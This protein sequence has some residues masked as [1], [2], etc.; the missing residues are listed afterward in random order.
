[1]GVFGSN[2]PYG[3]SYYKDDEAPMSSRYEKAQR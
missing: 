2:F 3:E 1:M